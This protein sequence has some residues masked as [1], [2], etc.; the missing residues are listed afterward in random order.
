MVP[1]V[2]VDYAPTSA[3]ATEAYTPPPGPPFSVPVSELIPVPNQLGSA[4]G[5]GLENP[6]AVSDRAVLMIV[7]A[8]YWSFRI[9]R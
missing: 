2:G 7:V 4:S 6:P 1:V 5:R 9:C 3:F 8:K